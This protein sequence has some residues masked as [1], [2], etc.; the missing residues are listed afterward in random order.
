MG[1]TIQASAK[2][3]IYPVLARQPQLSLQFQLA[4]SNVTSR[5]C[6][7]RRRVPDQHHTIRRDKRTLKAVLPM[8][9]WRRWTQVHVIQNGVAYALES[10]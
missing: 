8:R 1:E 6:F 9:R 10:K 4:F 2:P 5:A 3:L 7:S